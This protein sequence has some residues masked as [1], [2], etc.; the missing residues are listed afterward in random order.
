[1]RR[2]S[3]TVVSVVT[4]F[5]VTLS[6]LPPAHAEPTKNY[7]WRSDPASKILAGKP[8]AD[9]VLHRVPGSLH[10]APRVPVEAERAAARRV[11]LYGPG[12]PIYVGADAFCTVAVAGY[13]NRGEKVAITAGHCGNV[14]DPVVSADAPQLGRTGTVSQVNRQL[15][16]A[17]ITLARNAEVTRSYGGTTVNAVGGAPVQFGTQVCKRGV[18]SGTTCG[19]TFQDWENFNVN[20][21][22]AMPGDS[23]A[24]LMVGDRVIGL[25]NGGTFRPPFDIACHTP[26]QGVL[27]APTGAVRMDT[28]LGAMTGGFRLP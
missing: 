13:N 5:A 15:D 24:P 8:N 1:M 22:C 19:P 26:L 2:L 14:G 18:A 6:A 25:V 20:H 27:H 10:D 16:Y 28:V 17:V 3:A 21:V 9:R 12:T 23:G 7:V 4:A 11:A